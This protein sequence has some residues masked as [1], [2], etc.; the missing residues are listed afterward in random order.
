MSAN[1]IGEKNHRYGKKVPKA[2]RKKMSESRKGKKN[3]FFG[4]NHSPETR[5]FLSEMMK[6]RGNGQLGLKRSKASIKRMSEAQKGKEKIANQ[7]PIICHQNGKSYKSMTE[8]AKKLNLN[9]NLISAVV[10][11]KITNTRGYTFSLVNLKKST[12]I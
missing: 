8:A 9:I 1:Q 6:K 4:K 7:K 2:V 10:N 11:G 5:K 3:H 12:K